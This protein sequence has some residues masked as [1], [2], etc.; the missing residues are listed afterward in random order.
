MDEIS[1]DLSAFDIYP[2]KPASLLLADIGAKVV[3]PGSRVL[4]VCTGSGIIAITI[5]K[6]VS[7]CA[8]VASDL[9]PDAI[10]CAKING[11]LNS[12]QIDFRV[13]ELFAQFRDEEF[14]VITAHP[15]AVPCLPDLEW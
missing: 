14:D 6:L 3:I 11:E 10:D 5:A 7:G 12:V 4:D 13:G 15:P 1:I 9:N 2:P 8:V